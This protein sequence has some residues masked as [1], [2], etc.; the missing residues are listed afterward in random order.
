MNKP[1]TRAEVITRRTYCRPLNDEGTIFETW[2]DTV[3]RVMDHQQW[4]WERAQGRD[5][6]DTQYAELYEL[7]ELMLDRKVSM[8]GRTLWLGGTDVAKVREASQF[9]CSFTQVETVYDLVDILWLLLQG[10]PKHCPV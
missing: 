9:N 6:D 2:K 4:L 7:E 3:S 10:K 5:L 1:S 8:S